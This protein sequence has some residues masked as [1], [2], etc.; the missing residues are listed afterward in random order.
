MAETPRFEANIKKLGDVA[1]FLGAKVSDEFEAL[2]ITG[3]SSSSKR[4][5]PGELFIALPGEKHHGAKFA[6]DAK[7]SGA[8]ALLTD[9]AG[10]EL[11]SKSLG[12]FPIL[13]VE[14]PRGISGIWQIGLT[15]L[16]VELYFWQE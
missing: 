3:L 6:L 11:A 4:I 8:I 9:S 2:E 5:K 15:T 1:S 12:D 13:I 14:N 16:Q 10:L 7:N